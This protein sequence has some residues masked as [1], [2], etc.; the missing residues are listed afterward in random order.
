[1]KATKSAVLSAA[2]IAIFFLIT[3]LAAAQEKTSSTLRQP[4]AAVAN[5][6]V[7]EGTVVSFTANSNVPPI[8]AHVVVQTTSGQ[9]D[10][11]LGNGALLKQSNISLAPGDAIRIAGSNVP[12]GNGTIFA[13]RVLQKGAQSVTLRNARG[14]PLAEG[15]SRAAVRETGAR[16]QGVVQ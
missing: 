1:M 12:F 13:A 10:V 5:D 9:V 15:Q 4:S 8:G 2:V 3:S 7:I 11:H 14:I 16:A 6:T